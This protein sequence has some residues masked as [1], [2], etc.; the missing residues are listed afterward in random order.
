MS[1]RAL[2]VLIVIMWLFI[3]GIVAGYELDWVK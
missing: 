1:T 2:I 3:I